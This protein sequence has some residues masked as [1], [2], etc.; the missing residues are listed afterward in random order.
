MI[1]RK[2]WWLGWLIALLAGAP[3]QSQ[4]PRPLVEITPGRAR[5]FRA[6][7]QR[8]AVEPRPAGV[9]APDAE[10]FRARLEQSIAFSSI[11][12]PLQREAF[13]ASHRTESLAGSRRYDCGDWTQ[14]GADA[15]VEGRIRREAGLIYVDFQVWDP[16]RCM[17]LVEKS[18]RGRPEDRARVARRIA[19]R[20]R[21]LAGVGLV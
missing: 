6:A 19:D 8:F 15:L 3:A 9:A 4:E 17:R 20:L 12:M 10:A 1:A 2:F 18:Y 5:A 13:L 11:V 21:P 16:A 7:V 14:S